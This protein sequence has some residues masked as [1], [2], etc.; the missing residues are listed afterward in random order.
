MLMSSSHTRELLALLYVV[1]EATSPSLRGTRATLA[2]GCPVPRA[3]PRSL[4]LL[5]Q[6]PYHL[7]PFQS[8]YTFGS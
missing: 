6:Y 7:H 3:P 8:I 4:H 1:S 2:T 5:D